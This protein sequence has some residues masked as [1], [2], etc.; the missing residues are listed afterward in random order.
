MLKDATL[1]IVGYYPYALLFE[2]WLPASEV[3]APEPG[4]PN[5][6][7]LLGFSEGADGRWFAANSPSG[8]AFESANFAVEYIYHPTAQQMADMTA[9]IAGPF[10]SHGSRSQ[11]GCYENILRGWQA[12]RGGGHAVHADADR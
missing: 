6:G 12:H 8:R 3:V 4:P 10:G 7:V 9:E 5:P 1:E 2:Y 11:A